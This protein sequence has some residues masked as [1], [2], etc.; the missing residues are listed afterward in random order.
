MTGRKRHLLVDSQGLLM[1]VALTAAD[2][3]DRRPVFDLLQRAQQR[4]PRLGKVFVDKGYRGPLYEPILNRLHI[5]LTL[6]HRSQFASPTQV[7]SARWVVERA[8]AWLGRYR[9][10]SK[11]YEFLPAS[12]RSFIFLAMT[13][14]VLRRLSLL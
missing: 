14:L 5:R 6:E 11:D 4:Y 2:V 3:D 1:E 7:L 9:R 8:F 12:S 10:L 13:S